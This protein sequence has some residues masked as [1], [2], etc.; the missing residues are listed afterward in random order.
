M[1]WP[2]FRYPALFIM[3]VAAGTLTLNMIYEG[4]S[5]DGLN[6]KWWKKV[7]SSKGHTQLKTSTKRHPFKTEMAK[8]DYQIM[9]KMAEKEYT[10]GPHIPI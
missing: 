9:T 5:V 6:D 1:T 3:T 4:D 7:A 8:I 10:L 2:K